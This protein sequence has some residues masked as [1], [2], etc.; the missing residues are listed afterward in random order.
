MVAVEVVVDVSG[1]TRVGRLDVSRNLGSRGQSLGAAAGDLDLGAGDVELRRRAGVVDSELLDAEEVLASSEAGGDGDRVV[2]YEGVSFR[3]STAKLI[4][5]PFR[6][7]VAWPP[8]KVGPI[9]LILTQS[10]EP[11]AAA[12]LA[13][14]VT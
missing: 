14:L 11:S 6:S 1:V 3:S 9:S 4:D 7:H 2:V 10:E 8:E 12:A 13:T 5:V